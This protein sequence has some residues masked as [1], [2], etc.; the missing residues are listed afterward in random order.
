MKN[1]VKQR[2]ISHRNNFYRD[3]RQKG[4][5]SF[6]LQSPL[7]HVILLEV[8]IADLEGEPNCFEDLIK[9]IPNR[10]GSRSTINNILNDFVA[11]KYFCK[12]ISK[13]DKREK[14]YS[15]CPGQLEL[16][17]GWINDKHKSLKEV[18]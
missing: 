13:D 4:I 9:Y 15:I 8:A 1:L 16:V 11:R 17:F 12:R 3:K 6:M 10:F 7:H 2:L 5:V 14:V 18:G